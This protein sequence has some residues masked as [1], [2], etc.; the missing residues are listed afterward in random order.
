MTTGAKPALS[1]APTP[2]SKAAQLRRELT[3]PE[4]SFL[5]EAHSGLSA[6]IVEEA[7]FRGIWA[8]GLAVSAALG[9]RD[10]NE[11]SWTQ[12]LEI[13]EFMSDAT[14]IPILVDGDTGY[15]N[16]NNLRR[17]VKKLCQHDIA[18]VCIED[19]LFPKTNSFIGEAQPLA[20][21]EEFC[22]K[23]K[24]GKDSQLDDDF[25]L[26]ARIE[27]LIAGWGLDEA[28]RRAEAYHAAGADAILI[29]S[30][31][32]T[33]DEVLTFKRDW[34]DRCPVV[35]VPTMYYETPTETF[36]RAGISMVI[37]ANHNLRAS[38]S[39]MRDVCR[40]IYKE[41]G[42]VA[43]EGE[44][45]SIQ[46][47]FELMGNQELAEAEKRYLTSTRKETH[48]IVIA[49]S[50]GGKLGDLTEN[51]PK[52]M[53]DIRGK[54]LL[55]RLVSTLNKGGVRNV[56][57]V[58]GYKK[59]K[60]DLPSITTVDNDSYDTTGEAYSLSRALPHMEGDCI[61]SYGDILFRRFILDALL[62]ST[63]DMVLAVDAR[64]QGHDFHDAGRNVDLVSCTRPF[65]G[66]YLE[67]IE[68]AAVLKIGNDLS[69]NEVHGEW[70]GL[71]RTNARGSEIIRKQ[72]KVMEKA[73]KLE[74]ATLL[75]IFSAIIDAG[76]HI[77]ALYVTGH[78][79]D[80]DD[81][82]DLAEAR[83]FT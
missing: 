22:G 12:V 45:T 58:R 38:I 69:S 40:K 14:T 26:I 31:L 13:L 57:V 35:I 29:H 59:E 15:G 43:I 52:C 8:S 68:P 80:V 28:L 42:L 24:A 25:S 60:I 7:G 20:E 74:T 64:G 77:A 73:G 72:L 5:M 83:N 81:A 9:V 1:I 2:L 6:K 48:G 41:Q 75:D 66:D 78:W 55:R 54:P 21:I 19:K 71:A 18:G 37:W 65:S 67:E 34:C 70:I 44:V 36:S 51:Q 82:F 16:F 32:A 3:S 76:H 62:A 61:L 33:A 49:A 46:D 56:T 30:K 63:A 27:A 39:A 17:L 4:L 47:V 50:R 53:V 11:A 23:I 10:S 79:L